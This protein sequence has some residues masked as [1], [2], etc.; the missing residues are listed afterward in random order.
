MELDLSDDDDDDDDDDLD[1][2]GHARA[3]HTAGEA[4]S[5][6][7]AGP[8]LGA[9]TTKF[10]KKASPPDGHAFTLTPS[11]DGSKL[12]LRAALLIAAFCLIAGTYLTGLLRDDAAQAASDGD[13]L[14]ISN[15][16]TERDGD[17]ATGSVFSSWLR[18]RGSLAWTICSVLAMV[19]EHHACSPKAQELCHSG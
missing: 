4:S 15:Y 6:L 13:D 14:T 7:A 12:T 2:E 18:R 3:P 1:L 8:S 17:F 11:K 19:V 16:Y 9:A 5:L 10:G